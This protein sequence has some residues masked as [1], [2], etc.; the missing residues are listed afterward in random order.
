MTASPTLDRAQATAVVWRR[1]L[2]P[3][4][5]I[6]FFLLVLPQAYFVWMSFHRGLAMGRISDVLTFGNYG[7]IL[8]DGYYLGSMWKTVYLSAEAAAIGLILAFPTAYLLVRLRSRWVSYLIVLLLISS[9]VS[10]V[11][12]VLGLSLLLDREGLV[13][14]A[15]Q[16]VGLAGAPIRMTNNEVG[17]L[18]GLVQYTLPLIVMLLFSAIQ[19]IP[20]SL[21][22]AAE[23]HGATWSSMMFSVLLPLAKPGLIG[24][25]LV[26]FN[27]NMG[28]FTSAVLLGG[29]RVLT[30]PVLI[31]R[32]IILDVDYATGAALSTLLLVLVMALNLAALLGFRRSRDPNDSTMPSGH[33]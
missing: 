14:Q 21:E 4:L 18:I 25:A 11:M 7:R 9:F 28:A 26:A 23:I 20:E 27:M 8:T 32:K 1:F 30:L 31:Q 33:V 13:N 12:K 22:H 29:G 17:V 3:P 5:L 6:S 15:F 16:W 10:V 24:A 19:T 2:W